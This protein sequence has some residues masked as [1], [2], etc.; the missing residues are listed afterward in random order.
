MK[1]PADAV[2]LTY[3]YKGTPAKD[4]C[5]DKMY[6]PPGVTIIVNSYKVEL[7]WVNSCQVPKPPEKPNPVT[8]N[9]PVGGGRTTGG[10]GPGVGVG[11]GVGVGDGVGVG[12][13]RV[14]IS[15]KK[16]QALKS[17]VNRYGCGIPG[18]T[19]HIPWGRADPK[20]PLS[21]FEFVP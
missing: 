13:G 12:V 1:L 4:D 11:V 10:G 20:G 3:L 19:G 7:I 8:N 21:W 6:D 14:I 2:P 9:R 16:V 17:T 5:G 15:N 18:S